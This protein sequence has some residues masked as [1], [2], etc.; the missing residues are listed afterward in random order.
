MKEIPQKFR[1]LVVVRFAR[2]APDF[3][4][5][6]NQAIVVVNQGTNEIGPYAVLDLYST[7]DDTAAWDGQNCTRDLSY[8]TAERW[9]LERRDKRDRFLALARKRNITWED[10]AIMRWTHVPVA[11]RDEFTEYARAV[12]GKARN[13]P[14][15]ISAENLRVAQSIEDWLTRYSKCHTHPELRS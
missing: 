5:K 9:F 7:D 3:N 8:P 10:I 11:G 12:A 2:I 14:Q 13:F 4:E 15:F 1:G 6:P